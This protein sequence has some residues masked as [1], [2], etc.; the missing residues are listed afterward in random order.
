MPCG[1][2]CVRFATVVA[3]V[4]LWVLTVPVLAQGLDALVGQWVSQQ[5]EQVTF[6]L[7]PSGD[8]GVDRIEGV[9]HVGGDTITMRNANGVL[10]YTYRL[11]GGTLTF[12]GGDL[13]RPVVF[14]RVV[15]A[16]PPPPSA[17]PQPGAGAFGRNQPRP[18][19]SLVGRWSGARGELVIAQDGTLSLNGEPASAWQ[20]Q[21]TNIAVTDSQGTMLVPYQLQGNTLSVVVQGEPMTFQ[22][23]AGVPPGTARVAQVPQEPQS[24]FP[25]VIPGIP[26][27]P[28]PAYGGGQELVGTWRYMANVTAQGGGRMSQSC[29]TLNPNYTYSFRADTSTSTAYGGTSSAASDSGS[30]QLRDITL[31]ANSRS[32]GV[33]QYLL[34]KRNHPRTGDPMICLSGD[35][36]V[37]ATQRRPW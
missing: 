24:P 2:K 20:V 34:E 8:C 19:S 25:G 35:C 33:R 23:L 13:D 1:K 9:C 21:G 3:V 11:Q 12:S 18:T 17:Q 37:T 27:P 4:V 28:A 16:A 14:R 30:W 5:G 31:I 32:R 6:R 29:F 36:Y 10:S 7:A 22:R 15:A 26:A